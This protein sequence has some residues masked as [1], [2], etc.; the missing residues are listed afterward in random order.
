MLTELH[1][2]Q[3][4]VPGL[5]TY[6]TVVHVYVLANWCQSAGADLQYRAIVH[7][8]VLLAVVLF[9][10]EQKC[11]SCGELLKVNTFP[12]RHCTATV[13]IHDSKEHAVHACTCMLR[14]GLLTVHVHIYT[15]A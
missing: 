7:Q 15:R 9:A 11:F 1:V 2:K 6:T 10:C 5:Y 3:S 4:S 8:Q 14:Q 12:P 13:G